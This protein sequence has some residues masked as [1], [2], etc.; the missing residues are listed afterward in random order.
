VCALPLQYQNLSQ[1][2][3]TFLSNIAFGRVHT[4]LRCANG[5]MRV[6]DVSERREQ[7]S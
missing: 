3:P 7:D 5:K 6:G 2:Q 4:C 1:F